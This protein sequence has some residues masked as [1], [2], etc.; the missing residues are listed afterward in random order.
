MS[1]FKLPTHFF[2]HRESPALRSGA[3]KGDGPVWGYMNR[4]LNFLWYY[5]VPMGHTKLKKQSEQ[6]Y[7]LPR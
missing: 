1:S 3:G 4:G 6:K 2:L 5:H 7:F